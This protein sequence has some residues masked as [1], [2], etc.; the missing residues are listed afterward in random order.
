MR[1]FK[2]KESYNLTYTPFVVQATVKALLEFPKMNASI[3]GTKIK[4]HRNVNIGLAVSIDDGLIVPSI[5]HCEEK[6]FG[7]LSFSNDIANRAREGK[8]T[9]MSYQVL[10]LV[11]PI[12]EYLA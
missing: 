11:S 3:D 4:Y 10:H 8:I 2:N 6:T 5:L 7:H 9:L 12:L 1:S